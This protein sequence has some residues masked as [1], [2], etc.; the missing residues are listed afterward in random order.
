MQQHDAKWDSVHRRQS[1]G[2][3]C[4][5]LSFFWEQIRNDVEMGKID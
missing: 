1:N 2:Y 3:I 4:L 5:K